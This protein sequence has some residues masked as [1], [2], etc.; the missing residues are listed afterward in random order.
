M[1]PFLGVASGNVDTCKNQSLTI[2]PMGKQTCRPI[3][4]IKHSKETP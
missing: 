1:S 3:N 2:C 4:A